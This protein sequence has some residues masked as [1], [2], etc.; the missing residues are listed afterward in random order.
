MDGDDMNEQKILT[1]ELLEKELNVL[2]EKKVISQRIAEKIKH[3]IQKEK[4]II[5]QNDLIKLIDHVQFLLNIKTPK[6][7]SHHFSDHSFQNE[8]LSDNPDLSMNLKYN[9]SPN[10]SPQKEIS[11]T[12]KKNREKEK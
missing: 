12:E 4:L 3:K 1:P 10:N 7:H 11:E 5:N 2:V 6:E 8:D 9:S